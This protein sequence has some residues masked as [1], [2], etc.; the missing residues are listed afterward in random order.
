MP[1]KTLTVNYKKMQ[2]TNTKNKNGKCLIH[3]FGADVL[4]FEDVIFDEIDTDTFKET[5]H[6]QGAICLTDP[7]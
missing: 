6:A 5:K 3:T 4:N 2:I 7:D 1:I